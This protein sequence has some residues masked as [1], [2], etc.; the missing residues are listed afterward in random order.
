MKPNYDINKIKLPDTST[1]GFAQTFPKSQ[2][3]FESTPFS[4]GSENSQLFETHNQIVKMEDK[5]IENQMRKNFVQE[6]SSQMLLNDLGLV[7]Y[8]DN[9]QVPQL[10][11]EQDDVYLQIS[12]NTE[13]LA[14]G[15]KKGDK[16]VHVILSKGNA[17]VVKDEVHLPNESPK[18]DKKYPFQIL[19]LD[20]ADQGTFKFKSYS[21]QH[22]SEM[23]DM[24]EDI[25]KVRKP[26]DNLL[27]TGNGRLIKHTGYINS[28]EIQALIGKAI[29]KKYLA[30]E[31]QTGS[32]S[33][34]E[35]GKKSSQGI[36]L[37]LGNDGKLIKSI[38]QQEAQSVAQKAAKHM[39]KSRNDRKK[40]KKDDETG[41]NLIQC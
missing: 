9:V 20:T 8:R 15:D 41:A 30:M 31:D 18:L 34:S 13:T 27:M 16:K 24:F 29:Q 11:D 21:R 19:S 38:Y 14:Q 35:G 23:F 22:L 5:M 6:R 40:S 28:S 4:P 17:Q 12:D 33:L 7:Q 32:K 39:Q 2:S 25:Q 26:N 1:D 36:T 10:E 37:K 3:L